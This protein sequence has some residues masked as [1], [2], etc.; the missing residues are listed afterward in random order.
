[1]DFK[2]ISPYTPKGD[3]SKVIESIHNQLDQKSKY[4]TIL[5][6]TG[7]GKTYVMAKIIEKQQRPALIISH[8]KTLAAQLYREFQQFFPE[9]SVQYFV[10]YYDYYQPEAYVAKRDLYIEKDAQINDEIDKLRLRATS[11]LIE[12]QDVVIIASVSCIF[13]LGSPEDYL[14]MHL[15]IEVGQITSR[16]DIL[17]KLID[18]LYER[19][20][21][22]LE[23]GYFRVRGDTIDII[24]TYMN[25][26]G[27]RIEMFGNEIEALFEIDI[28]NNKPIKELSTLFIYP[29]KHFVTTKEKIQLARKD[30]LLELEERCRYFESENK[31]LEK[32]R[33][34]T[35]TQYDLELL[36][37]VGFCKGI[38]NYSRHLT[39]RKAG[40]TPATLID[41]FPS[42]FLTFIDESHVSL[43]QIEGMYNG[44]RARKM[45][46]VEYGYRLPS[47]LD[48]RPLYIDEFWKSVGQTVFVS[49]TPGHRELSIGKHI[50]E[51]IIR[52]TG[53]V[54]PMIEVRPTEGQ[55]DDLIGEMN[56][57]IQKGFRILITTLTKK[58]AEDL[59][60]F[61]NDK[62]FRVKYIHSDTETIE[63][64]EIITMLRKN[65]ID[66][67]VGINLLREG[68]DIPEVALVVIFDADKIGFLR[69]KSSLIQTV[70]RASRNVKGRVIMYADKTS[71]AMKECI[72]ENERRRTLQIEYNQ[73]N[74]I[75]PTTIIKPI[76]EIIER[77]S[78]EKKSTKG[79]KE[80]LEKSNHTK[81]ELQNIIKKMEFE[82]NQAADV[83]NFE[84]AIEIRNQI[85]ILKEK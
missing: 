58:M 70:G 29:A 4:Q 43:P 9:N 55:V 31:L 82:M 3:Q 33:L 79:F 22:A 6:A 40:E 85:K 23:R 51:L 83:L 71:I 45:S 26:T 75:E 12:R 67:I 18:M 24:P 81:K 54:D 7:T 20:D 10:S 14:K 17:M 80:K 63:R 21:S 76:Y 25:T 15:R 72:E 68:L 34:Y 19:Q 60:D 64:V 8:N 56:K 38:E 62:R 5:G 28:L 30:I 77:T 84:K 13:G 27:Y 1:M 78:D 39:R 69:S 46:L 61:L 2:V 50:S 65:N 41:Y 48:N 59:T 53:L 57:T 11:S 52:P 16:R 32:E 37:S 66:A 42:N 35:R 49:A 74:N 73:K 36:E 44:D 47:A